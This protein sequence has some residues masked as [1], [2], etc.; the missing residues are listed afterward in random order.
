MDSRVSHVASPDI[1]KAYDI[2]G[3]Y[4]EQIDGEVAEQI[5]SAF[6]QVLAD[7]A[8]KRRAGCAWAS[9]ATCA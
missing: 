5:G 7:L 8:G 4:D 3:L 6:A 1:F 2:R 9:G